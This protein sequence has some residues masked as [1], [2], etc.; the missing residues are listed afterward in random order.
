MYASPLTRYNAGGFAEKKQVTQS[1]VS[2][3]HYH[4]FILVPS[5]GTL[6]LLF[7]AAQQISLRFREL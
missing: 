5:K 2:E 3:I 6:S 7:R 4:L 1:L